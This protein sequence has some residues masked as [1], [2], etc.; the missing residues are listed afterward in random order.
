VRD[1]AALVGPGTR[2]VRPTGAYEAIS[3]FDL[4][5]AF[6]LSGTEIASLM[7]HAHRD[8][9]LAGLTP[10]PGGVEGVRALESLGHETGDRDRRRQSATRGRAAGC[11]STVWRIW[12]CCMSINTAAPTRGVRTPT[13]RR[14]WI[15]TLAEQRFDVAID[16]SPLAL[17]LLAPRRDCLVIVYDRPWNR[18]YAQTANMRRSDSWTEIV[19]LIRRSVM[20][21]GPALAAVSLACFFVAGASPVA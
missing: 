19:A 8:D 18:R 13:C 9:F 4:Q 11:A 1:R 3:G 10:T 15:A 20:T 7:E 2:T 21:S 12:G 16:D 5:Q 14:H 17:D 6:S